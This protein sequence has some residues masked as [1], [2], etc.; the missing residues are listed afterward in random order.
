MTEVTV[1]KH[2]SLDSMVSATDHNKLSTVHH[3]SSVLHERFSSGMHNT[4]TNPMD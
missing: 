4:G 1:S 3:H 2:V